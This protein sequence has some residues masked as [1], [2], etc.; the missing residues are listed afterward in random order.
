[1]ECQFCKKEKGTESI[2][3][4]ETEQEVMIC[5]KCE[6]SLDWLPAI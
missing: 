6:T 4:S 2:T 5:L 3:D 1:M